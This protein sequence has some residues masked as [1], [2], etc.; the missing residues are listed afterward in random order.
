M[1]DESW[2]EVATKILANAYKISVRQY[3]TYEWGSKRNQN[4]ISVVVPSDLA[5]Q[6]LEFT[7]LWLPKNLKSFVGTSKWSGTN[8]K[9]P[10]NSVEV[11]IAPA[12]TQ[13]DILHVA[14]TAD[15]N[16]NQSTEEII[17]RLQRYDTQF[18]IN[19]YHA[20]DDAVYFRLKQMPNN[21]EEF[22]QDIE[23]LCHDTVTQVHGTPE[24][25]RQQVESSH[26][27]YLWWD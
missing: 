24:L 19:I 10:A 21:I 22:V 3:S 1:S 20:Q 12:P 18:G 27:V 11:V 8:E 4:A 16:G 2:R 7:R 5:Y 6:Y 25:F 13:F 17:N 14:H 23:D 26:L 9:H 15:V